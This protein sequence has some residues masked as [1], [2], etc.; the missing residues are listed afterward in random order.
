MGQGQHIIFGNF[1]AGYKT[2]DEIGIPDSA[3]SA[4]VMVNS[5]PEQSMK[6][7]PGCLGNASMNYAYLTMAY[8]YARMQRFLKA[9]GYQGYYC[10]FY[11][12]QALPALCGLGEK[13]RP[14]LL[15]TPGRGAL[16]RKMDA[17]LTD[18]P[19]PPTP[20]ID[21]G[22]N[23]FCHTCKKCAERCPTAAIPTETDPSW[24]V[25]GPWNAVGVKDW[26]FDYPTCG[27]YKNG[28]AP[29]YCG[30]CLAVCPFSKLDY[31]PIHE[32]VQGVGTITGIFDGFFRNMDDLFGYGKNLGASL[33]HSDDTYIED[34]WNTLGPEFGLWTFKGTY[35]SYG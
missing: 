27:S 32:F 17:V 6:A 8:L 4:I 12:A 14:G 19:L 11:G 24:E 7:A 21:A 5:H 28:W 34:W 15:L 31:A 26:S 35:P 2:S 1:P 29:G 10:D 23:K 13:G 22:Q 9:L 16:V 3:R 25:T 30:M 20:P 33:S 18:L